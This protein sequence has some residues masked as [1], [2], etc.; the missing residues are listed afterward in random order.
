MTKG[1]KH[2]E[3]K[4][5]F[6]LIDPEFE[7]LL[8]RVLT[9]GAETYG[10]NNWQDLEDAEHRYLAACRRHIN[11]FSRG[12]ILDR[13]SGLPHVVHAA[14]NLMFLNWKENNNEVTDVRRHADQDTKSDDEAR[15][16]STNGNGPNYEHKYRVLEGVISHILEVLGSSETHKSAR[17]CVVQLLDLR[18]FSQFTSPTDSSSDE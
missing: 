2:D 1:S 15:G 7:L 3:G 5:R 12:E 4:P 11:K 8:A 17:A 10:D 18:G 13:D 16:A 9:K 14:C 6:D